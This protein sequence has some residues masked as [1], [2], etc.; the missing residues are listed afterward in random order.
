MKL[1]VRIAFAT[2]ALALGACQG[3]LDSGGGG[4]PGMMGL[5]VQQPGP[6]GSGEMQGP[7]IGANGQAELTAPGAT[8]APNQSQFAVGDAPNGVKCPLFQQFTCTL[9]FNV[10]TPSPPP[11]P[12][13]TPK[14]TPKPTPSPSPSP[15]ASGS[16]DE[17]SGDAANASPTPPGTVTLQM[18][19]L[20]KDVPAMT[21]PDPRALRVTPLVAIRLQSDTDFAL[22][23]MAAV[24]YTMPKTQILTRTFAIQLYNETALR[25]KRSDQYLATYG[26]YTAGDTTIDFTFATPRVTVKRGQIWLLALYGFQFPP[27]TTPTPA[28]DGST[29]SPSPS[30]SSAP[31]ASP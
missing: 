29:P 27:G 26:K 4:M 30:A 7:T 25:G 5:P 17:D 12:G 2:I 8:L 23:G 20:P 3:G 19:P 13:Q 31:T 15:S 24:Q 1:D 10:P 11:S 22:N 28:P 9:A 21:N 6:M 18:E 14:P 16:E